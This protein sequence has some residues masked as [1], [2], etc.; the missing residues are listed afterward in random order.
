MKLDI[1]SGQAYVVALNEAKLQ[2]HEYLTPEHY[3]YAI[4]MFDS[5]KD[6]IEASGGDITG[7]TTDLTEFFDSHIPK[8][9]TETPTDSHLFIKM[10]ELS[11]VQARSLGRAF[12]T[13]G[14]ILASI[15]NLNESFANFIMQS[16]GVDRLSLM[17]YISSNTST[18][19]Q[20]A[21]I[22]SPKD[23][24]KE[25]LKQYA[26]NLTDKARASQLDPVI[27]RED[28]MERTIQVLCRRLK[29][30]PVHVGDPGVGKTSIVEGLAQKIVD[31]D[32]PQILADAQIFYI[33]MG[34]LVA[35]TKYRGDFEERLIKLLDIIAKTKNPIIYID[36]I[37]TVVGAGSVS[38]GGM[39]ATSIIKPF[40]AKGELRFIGSTTFEEFKKY[41]DKDR[42]LSRRFAR[43]D[44]NEPSVSDCI[45]IL[46]GI[47]HKYEQYHDVIFTDEIIELICNLTEKHMQDRFF[48][49]KAIDVM[50]E[51]GAFAKMSGGL[52]R[53]ISRKEIEKTISLMTKLPENSVSGDEMQMLL[54]LEDNIKK[55]IFGQDD[56]VATVVSAIK[57]AR[58]GLNDAEKPVASMLF[59]GPTGVGK[60]EIAIQLAGNLNVKLLR[61]DM[62][63]YQEKHSV[64]R[65]IGAPPG[66]VGYEE[67]GL[68]T[69]AI[70]KTPY[71]V[72]LLDEIEKAHPD[73]MNVLLQIMD[74]GTLTDNVGKKADF[75]NVIIIMTSNA[76]ARELGKRMIGYD[77]NAFNKDAVDKEVERV[78][79]P[80]FRNRLDAIVLFNRIDKKMARLITVK[81]INRLSERLAQKGITFKPSEALIDFISA[82]G[83]SETYGA[84]EIIRTVNNDLK[85]LFVNEMLFGKPESGGTATATV[86][87]GVISVKIRRSGAKAKEIPESKDVI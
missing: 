51:V 40:L 9:V 23:K 75:K 52:T 21:A 64:A 41:F 80:E 30:N 81:A 70:K 35:G 56:A 11:T 47:K 14:D 13:V 32:V 45:K 72:L 57:A 17:K 71:C 65:L 54:N 8:K 49:D 15:F 37:H 67:G 29:N 2:N 39:D 5:G 73:I 78:F 26:T 31:G 50:D 76:G 68:L 1:L 4:L 69:D 44:V 19:E 60:T 87:D 59:V 28:I 82:K 25:F 12:I 58:S 63:E 48:P 42:A 3:L 10:L 7:I 16:N 77:S 22:A 34:S 83:L 43:I 86:K 24:D 38:G 55:Q 74:Y 53:V 27:G 85:R 20:Q 36:E 79:S 62:S 46:N 66:Y 84:R 33:D 6:I 18:T 61:Y